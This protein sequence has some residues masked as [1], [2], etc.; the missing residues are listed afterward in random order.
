MKI[1]SKF[2]DYYDFIAYQYGQDNSI[3]YNRNPFKIANNGNIFESI[4]P[5]TKSLYRHQNIYPSFPYQDIKQEYKFKWLIICG[6]KFLLVSEKQNCNL[7]ADYK[8][9]TI[10]QYNNFVELWSNFRKLPKYDYYIGYNEVNQL[11]INISKFIN[12]PIFELTSD[13][14]LFGSCISNIKDYYEFKLPILADYN[15]SRVYSPER[16]YQDLSYFIGNTLKDTPDTKPP[17]EVTNKDKI[18]GHGFDLKTSF[19][20]KND[21]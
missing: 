18:I 15:I 8:L 13:V 3:V 11:Y 19:R 6:K 4:K 21:Y 17:V 10:E 7:Y 12:Q 1:I 16:L 2:K 14:S 20:G 9:I 5:A